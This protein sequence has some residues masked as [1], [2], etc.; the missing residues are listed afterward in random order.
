MMMNLCYFPSQYI[1]REDSPFQDLYISQNYLYRRPDI[2]KNPQSGVLREHTIEDFTYKYSVDRLS[3]N[4]YLY[5]LCFYLPGEI[6]FLLGT[7]FVHSGIFLDQKYARRLC[8][9]NISTVSQQLDA[10]S[11]SVSKL[12][13][14]EINN[15]VVFSFENIFDYELEVIQPIYVTVLLSNSDFDFIYEDSEDSL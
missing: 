7:N 9:H 10:Y 15:E 11:I 2:M 13:I 3:Y 6:V 1:T 14:S 12:E 4:K 5:R 8:N